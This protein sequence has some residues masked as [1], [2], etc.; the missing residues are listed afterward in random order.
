MTGSDES[1]YDVT[2][3]YSL[4]YSH[5]FLFTAILSF[6]L[7]LKLK[8]DNDTATIIFH[9]ST[10][11]V[12]LCSIFGA[13]LA[14]SFWGKFK[15]I[16]WLSLVYACGSTC[17]AVGSFEP[18]G[19]PAKEYT[20]IGLLLI[21]LG[22]GGIK[23]CVS[24]FGGE[25]F[26]IPEQAEQL[27]RFFSVFYFAINAGSLLSTLITPLLRNQSC[28]GMDECYTAGFGLPAILMIISIVIFASGFSMYR[29]V[30]P[31]GN[32]IV[33]VAKCVGVSFD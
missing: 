18:F 27:A 11:L 7:T 30:P 24:A 13:I 9:L 17:V 10:T 21:A 8:Y 14:D 2:I 26:K 5:T 28:F 22:S 31:Q 20:I 16:F 29:M 33:K 15:T 25:Q 1:S 6:Y 12:Y 4:F 19:L 23:P 32:M 3:K